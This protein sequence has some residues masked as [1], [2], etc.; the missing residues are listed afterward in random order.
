[1]ASTQGGK[2]GNA[3]DDT[4][5][6][7]AS[8][9]VPQYSVRACC[10]T[11]LYQRSRKVSQSVT[12]A[13]HSDRSERDDRYTVGFLCSSPKCAGVTKPKTPSNYL[14]TTFQHNI[15]TRTYIIFTYI[16]FT[17]IRTVVLLPSF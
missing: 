7:H 15:A 3:L 1:M 9:K 6:V 8:I 17:Y 4:H 11:W 10:C 5:T 14:L 2:R 12:R 16:L 13:R